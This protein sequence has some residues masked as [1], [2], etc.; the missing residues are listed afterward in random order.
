MNRRKLFAHVLGVCGLGFLGSKASAKAQLTSDQIIR[1]WQ[2]PVFRGS[3]TKEQWEALP[4]NPAGDLRSGEFKGNL[5]MASGNNCSG[6]NCSGN[7]CSGNNC[8]GNNCSGNNCS[9]NNCSGNNCSG[10]RCSGNNCSGNR[11]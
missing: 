1:A 9:G 8:S 3:L 2:D 4:P 7:N 10:N 6:N 5:Q 11:C